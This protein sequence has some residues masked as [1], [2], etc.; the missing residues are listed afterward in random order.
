MCETDYSAYP[1]GRDDTLKALQ[2][3]L[4]L[5][6]DHS[7]TIETPLM[8]LDKAATW[9]LA[10]ELGG[11]VL[12]QLIREET[13]SCYLGERSKLFEWGRAAV[14]ARPAA[15]APP[16][17]S[18]GRRAA[19]AGRLKPRARVPAMRFEHLVQINDPLQPMRAEVAREQ[20]WRGL[21][22]RAE[23]PAEFVLGLAGA[24]IEQRI[25]EPGGCSSS[26]RWTS[27]AS[28]CTTACC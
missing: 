28:A 24:T 5:G 7:V 4:S 22:R 15:C 27:A 18:P 20:L 12:V 6:M 23:R 3:A 14:C 16:A 19:R 17:G 13:N 2:V 11:D 1:D 26:A 9:Q 25:D 8:W 10:H 21:V